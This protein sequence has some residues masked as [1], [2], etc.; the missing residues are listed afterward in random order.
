MYCSAF[1][2]RD[3]I[4]YTHT[5]NLFWGGCIIDN[6]R[7][8]KHKY[9]LYNYNDRLFCLTEKL[10]WQ[11]I[12]LKGQNLNRHLLHLLLYSFYK[13]DCPPMFLTFMLEIFNSFKHG[14][15]DKTKDL[16]ILQ[17]KALQLEYTYKSSSTKSLLEQNL[18][19]LDL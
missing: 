8:N 14:Y 6:L 18:I 19:R 1:L 13:S 3:N 7:I 10:I 2:W 9:R 11:S 12:C 4:G 16:P 15:W 17:S 5:K